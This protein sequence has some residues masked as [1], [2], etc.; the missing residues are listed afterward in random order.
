VTIGLIVL[1]IVVAIAWSAIL[2]TQLT[3]ELATL[4]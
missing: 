3:Q 1:S 2:I 4:Y